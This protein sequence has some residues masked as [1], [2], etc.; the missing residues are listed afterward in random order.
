M[1]IIEFWAKID[2]SEG[3]VVSTYIVIRYEISDFELHVADGNMIGEVAAV[4]FKFDRLKVLNVEIEPKSKG[5]SW[6]YVGPTIFRRPMM[7]VSLII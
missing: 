7:F 5:Y 2:I 1:R 4:P 3:V 6:N